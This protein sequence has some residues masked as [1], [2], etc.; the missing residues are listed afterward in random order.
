MQYLASELIS[1]K[2]SGCGLTAF[3]LPSS[4]LTPL[5]KLKSE[6]FSND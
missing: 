6:P 5:E 1:G 4:S 3:L 2:K